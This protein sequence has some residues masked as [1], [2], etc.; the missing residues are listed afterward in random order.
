MPNSWTISVNG[1]IYGPYGAADMQT[2]AAQGRLAAQS[3]VARAGETAF[4]PAAED[5]ELAPLFQVAAAGQSPAFAAEAGADRNFGRVLDGEKGEL[6][7][8]IIIA[9]M[10]S[11]SISGLEEAIFGFGPSYPLMPQAWLLA[12]AQPINTIRNTLVQKMGKIDCLFIVDASRHKAAWFNYMPEAE[13]RIRLIWQK[14][15]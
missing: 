14:A 13:S 2:Y 7:H 6:S 3:L 12:S 5:P 8:Y 1:Q 15:S 9:D 11:R 4:R 10:K